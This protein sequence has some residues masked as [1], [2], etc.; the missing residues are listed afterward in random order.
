VEIKK[1]KLVYEERH[2]KQKDKEHM[3]SRSVEFFYGDLGVVEEYSL[4]EWSCC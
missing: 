3:G 4:G 1:K 2:L